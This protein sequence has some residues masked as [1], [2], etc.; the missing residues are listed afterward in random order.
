MTTLKRLLFD[1]PLLEITVSRLCHQLIED[2]GDFSNSVI[3][4]LQPRG[5]HFANRIRKRLESLLN[6]EVPIG[7]LDVTFFRDDFRRRESPL[8]ANATHIP[9]IIEGKKVVLVDDVL[10]TGRTIRAAMDAMSAFGRPEQVDLLV[11]VDRLYTRDLP[12][13][14]RYTGRGVNT[15]DSQRILVEWQEQGHENDSIWL[16][17][18]G[19]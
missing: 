4:G 12:I 16:I 9:F 15:L 5:I 3:L 2:H 6:R 11:L 10:Y 19:E 8:K 13:E 7:Y 1:S 18:K 17:N 14:P